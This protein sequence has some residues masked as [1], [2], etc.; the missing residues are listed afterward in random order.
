MQP[1]T[2]TNLLRTVVAIACL[3]IAAGFMDTVMY[4]QVPVTIAI[5]AVASV[6]TT[7]RVYYD[8]GNE[9]GGAFIEGKQL[10][11]KWPLG[12]T[13]AVTVEAE[14]PLHPLY[15]FQLRVTSGQLVVKSIWFHSQ[16]GR[17]KWLPTKQTDSVLSVTSSPQNMT[18][19]EGLYTELY[20][21]K[22]SVKRRILAIL[23]VVVALFTGFVGA[24]I[25]WKML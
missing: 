25:M 11:L 24:R 4:R 12:S 6:P 15:G 16:M 17:I 2:K 23:I 22:L 7:V 1:T 5:T 3:V 21:Q 14:L 13:V 20:R 9:F 19:A 10:T 8:D 18:G